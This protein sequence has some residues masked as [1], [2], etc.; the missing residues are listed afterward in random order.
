MGQHTGVGDYNFVETP[1]W[2]VVW[3]SPRGACGYL[4]AGI[5]KVDFSHD[6]GLEF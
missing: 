4:G 1:V 5:E 2:M 3:F 6:L